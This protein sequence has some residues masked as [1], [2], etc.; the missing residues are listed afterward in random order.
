MAAEGDEEQQLVGV[1]PVQH[2]STVGVA[3]GFSCW[4]YGIEVWDQKPFCRMR[5]DG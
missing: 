2:S 5:C 1:D 3:G 4:P